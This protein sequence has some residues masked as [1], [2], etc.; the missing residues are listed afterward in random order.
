M[1]LDVI[2][3]IMRTWISTALCLSATRCSPM[4]Q[5]QWQKDDNYQDCSTYIMNIV[6]GKS[7]VMGMIQSK[8]NQRSRNGP[9]HNDNNGQ[10]PTQKSFAN[11]HFPPPHTH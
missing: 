8:I 9:P 3:R 5:W 10:P 11:P 1:A 7:F 4:G 2:K 6:G